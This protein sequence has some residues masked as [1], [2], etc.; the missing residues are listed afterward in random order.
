M[1]IEEFK[2][3]KVNFYDNH[4]TKKIENDLGLNIYNQNGKQ[5]MVLERHLE[6]DFYLK[7]QKNEEYEVNIIS[8]PAKKYD[9]FIVDLN[10]IDNFITS[11]AVVF[12]DYDAREIVFK[13][14]HLDDGKYMRFGV[15]GARSSDCH[16]G[17][18]V[19]ELQKLDLSSK[20]GN[21]RSVSGYM[22][23]PE[24]EYSKVVSLTEDGSNLREERTVYSHTVWVPNEADNSPIVIKVTSCNEEVSLLSVIHD[25]CKEMNIYASGIMAELVGNGEITIKGR[26]LK[27]IPEKAFSVL[28]EA[29]DIA[30]EKEFKLPRES[31]MEMYGTLYKRYEPEW[32]EFTDGRQYERRG[33]FH[34]FIR[35]NELHNIHEVFHVREV[36]LCMGSSVEIKIYPVSDIYRIYPIEE[37]NGDY[38]IISSNKNVEEYA[39]YF[40]EQDAQL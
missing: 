21:A 20:V 11:K 31:S 25:F 3:L 18:E 26:V 39:K 10:G 19:V 29:T 13:H 6:R 16:P 12:N 1:K 22:T 37:K 2:P 32:K 17:G 23:L 35:G 8:K 15:S 24:N 40:I 9:N 4:S 7:D 27:H 36:F 28:K 30:I 38:F 5:Y 33:H 34:A 14:L